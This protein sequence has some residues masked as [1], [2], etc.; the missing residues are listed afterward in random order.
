MITWKKYRPQ[1]ERLKQGT[2]PGWPPL[3]P[4]D[5]PLPVRLK[6]CSQEARFCSFQPTSKSRSSFSPRFF[7]K[8]T[9][10]NHSRDG[11]PDLIQ[12]ILRKGSRRNVPTTVGAQDKPESSRLCA[13]PTGQL[14]Q[15]LP[16]RRREV[17]TRITAAAA[18]PGMTWK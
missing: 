16:Q 3:P 18:A 17:L 1:S 2:V 11:P 14:L 5:A 15:H 12:T 10:F 9:T 8:V 6:G 7:P 13:T 4:G